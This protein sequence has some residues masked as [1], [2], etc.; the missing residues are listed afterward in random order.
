MAGS[1]R[2]RKHTPQTGFIYIFV[3]K[4]GGDI[5]ISFIIPDS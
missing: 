5:N 3:K 1:S 4:I 2:M